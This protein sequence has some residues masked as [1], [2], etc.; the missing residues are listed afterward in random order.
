MNKPINSQSHGCIIKQKKENNSPKPNDSEPL[1]ST[2][3]S[4]GQRY[5]LDDVLI[6]QMATKNNGDTVWMYIYHV[7]DL[8]KMQKEPE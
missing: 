7:N 8:N 1:R 6:T 2:I 3:K 4:N 5:L